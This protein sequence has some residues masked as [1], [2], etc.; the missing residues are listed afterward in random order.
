MKKKIGKVLPVFLDEKTKIGKKIGKEITDFHRQKKTEIGSP[1]KIFLLAS[2]G[3]HRG[4]GG[5]GQTKNANT[6][7]KKIK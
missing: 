1:K 5:Y 6:Q 4:E 3:F 7:N 2:Q